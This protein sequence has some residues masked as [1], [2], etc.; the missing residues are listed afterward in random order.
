M[1]V[2]KDVVEASL[3]DATQL[4][5][6]GTEQQQTKLPVN[7]PKGFTVAFSCVLPTSQMSNSL[8]PT[9]THVLL[10]S[11][12]SYTCAC[13]NVAHPHKRRLLLGRKAVTNLDNIL[14]SRDITL[15]TKVHI[16]KAMDLLMYGCYIRR[17]LGNRGK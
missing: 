15:P 4:F 6:L 1:A 8:F 13:L 16:V 17:R 7:I 12:K 3:N 5:T 11:S 10:E 9:K 2:V 14:K